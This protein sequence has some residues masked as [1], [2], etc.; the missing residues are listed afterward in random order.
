[1]FIRIAIPIAILLAGVGGWYWLGQPVAEPEPEIGERKKVK[2]ERLLL[3]PTDYQV[4]LESQGTVRAHHSTTLT[5]LVSGRIIK[6]Y[7]GFEDGAFFKEGEVLAE[8]DPSDLRAKLTGAESSLARAEANLA[9]EEARA[10][11]AKLNWEDI[12]YEEDPSPLVLR[13]PQLKEARALVTAAQADLEQARRDLERAKI[14]APFDGRVKTRS[15]GLGQAVNA[16][17][18]LGQVFTT[19]IAEVRLPLTPNQLRFIQLPA[20]QDDP[21]VDV[22]LTNSLGRDIPGLQTAWQ[23][24]I[25]RTE[26]ALD[27]KSRELFAIAR[28]E[29][30][31]GLKNDTPELRIGQPV[32]AEI[33]AAIIKDVFV[34]PR[35]AVRGIN[36]IY[37]IDP[38]ELRVI[39]TDIEPIWSNDEVLLV[40]E[41]IDNGDWLATSR[42]PHVSNGAPVEIIEPTMA[43]TAEGDGQPIKKDS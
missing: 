28:I 14:R 8:I 7:P 33:K 3:K 31:F 34:I 2:T 11:Q 10:K 1:M 13:E 4:I 6:I 9:R 36:R 24:R 32:R 5:P 18:P 43:E 21:P 19:E 15:I 25:I 30:P 41:G 27:A 16:T 29:D 12:G 39:R 26:G 20:H 17:T 23:A 42:M 35:Q 40:R 22:I 38:L 37:L